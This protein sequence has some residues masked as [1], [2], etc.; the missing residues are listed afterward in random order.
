MAMT[1]EE[2]RLYIVKY[3]WTPIV[4]HES[5]YKVLAWEHKESKRFCQD[6]EDSY[7]NEHYNQ[8]VLNK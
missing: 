3:G 6:I 8:E 2:M 7:H 1:Y 5:G 4:Y